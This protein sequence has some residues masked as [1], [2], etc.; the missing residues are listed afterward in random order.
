MSALLLNSYGSLP[1]AQAAMEKVLAYYAKTRSQR[2]TAHAFGVSVWTVN[3]IVNNKCTVTLKRILEWNRQDLLACPILKSVSAAACQE[4]SKI[5][6][7]RR[8]HMMSNPAKL[9]LYAA[10]RRCQQGG[11]H[12]N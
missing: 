12:A 5:A 10:C 3:A 6:R 11:N 9:K 8:A 2:K 1:D 4:H 7:S